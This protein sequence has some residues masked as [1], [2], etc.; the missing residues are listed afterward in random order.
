MA[1]L[2]PK[3][4]SAYDTLIS[5]GISKDDAFNLVTG[6]L[7]AEDFKL[8]NSE[9][10]KTNLKEQLDVEGFDYDLMK[11]TSEK[12][13]KEID[14]NQ[15]PELMGV[16]ET[17]SYAMP[18]TTDLFNLYGIRTDK[19]AP[20]SVR[21]KLSFGLNDPNSQIFNAKFLLGQNLIEEGMKPELVEKYKDKIDVQIKE[22]GKGQE[23]TSGMIFKL[24]KE[25]GGDG[26]Y[27]KF[28]T[29]TMLPNAGDLAAISG[30]SIP[31]AMSIAGGTFGSI[32]GPAGTVVGSGF[33]AGLGEYARL[34]IGRYKFGLNSYMSDEEFD[35]AAVDDAM[36]YGAIDA[37]ATAV[38]LP[39][40]AVVKQAI[41]TTPKERL[42][43]DT[44]KKFIKAGGAMDKDFAKNL[45]EARKVLIANG[46]T[47]KQADDYLAISVAKAIPEAGILEKGSLA[48]KL[49]FKQIKSAETKANIKEVETKLLKSLTGLNKVDDKAADVLIEGVEQDVRN[50]RN[51]ELESVSK[52]AGEA[53]NSIL[54][55]KDNIFKSGTESYIDDF[56][57]NFAGVTGK[58]ETRL[59]NLKNQ[60][61]ASI[62][63]S[64][65]QLNPDFG[66]EVKLLNNLIK[67]Y[68]IKTKPVPNL[69]K[70]QLSKLSIQQLEERAKNQNINNMINMLD[71]DGG[72]TATKNKI[73]VLSKGLKSIEEMPLTEAVKLRSMVITA[74]DNADIGK[75]Y[76]QSLRKL[77]GGLNKIIDDATANNPKLAAK[78]TQYDELLAAKQNS[79]FRDFATNFGY[80]GGKKVTEAVKY[81]GGDIFNRFVNGADALENSARLGQLIRTKGLFNSSEIT[82]MKSALYENYFS[83]VQPKEIGSKGVMSHKE[84]IE[85]YGKNY[86]L[87]LGDKEYK[88]FVK[89]TEGVMK[90]Y[91][92]IIQQT[93]DIQ[94][95]LSRALPGLEVNILDSG[96]PS[97]IVEH[98]INSGKM[99]NI[100]LLLKK[101][102]DN[103]ITDIRRI[104]LN[105]FIKG[106][107]SDLGG[108]ITAMNG[109][110]L[111]DFLTNNRSIIKQLFNDDF[112]NA[113]R[114]MANALEVIQ[115]PETLAKVGAPGLTDAANKAGLFVDIF[116]G[117][118][119]H[120]RL[121]IN[122][123]GRIYDGFDLG[124]D[125]LALLRD[126]NKFVEGAKKNFIAGNYPKFFDGL[127]P[128]Q[129]DN[130]VNKINLG[131]NRGLGV[132]NRY[133][134]KTNPLYAREYMNEK[135][136]NIFQDTQRDDEPQ[137]FDPIDKT[138]TTLGDVA[139]KVG[140][141]YIMP[142]INRLTKGIRDSKKRRKSEDIER[143]IFEEEKRP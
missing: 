121:I 20:A 9:G 32:V 15:A 78:I 136:G 83:K 73:Q 141:K 77:K 96:A 91:D 109:K 92:N 31:I 143:K 71:A 24:P 97:R 5:G 40:A 118:L 110:R 65:V 43:V 59:G 26:K 128:S 34:M 85:Q 23:K 50:I 53:F 112:F 75:G 93:A 8:K 69:N 139:S 46:L 63:N 54:K 106:T 81:K 55:S 124:G 68:T 21:G 1:D 140:K 122:R 131:L 18:S 25:L 28:N 76:G 4:L 49:Y 127:K 22:V 42:S 10:V 107:T 80:G 64:K 74:L 30:D 84:F 137:L 98:I 79:Y 33:S 116:A 12:I 37:G 19:E 134:F 17:L 89:G 3:Q 62:R 90:S 58:L 108:G 142:I 16:D 101:L 7:S 47:G 87:I 99:K 125:S 94:T 2:N 82:R 45:D 57:I 86:R 67:N 104:Y 6:N 138:A 35:K 129:F 13:K 14:P 133:S 41:F 44:M 60:I 48:D 115:S 95:T 114:S 36:L 61:D 70:E 103:L 120:K 130:I 113:H 105:Q 56:G 135:A 29:P 52:E 51:L 132:R 119:N 27:Y 123:L 39:L 117:P 66:E 11:K 102:P 126:Y 88:S 72:F 111:N 38:F 100:S